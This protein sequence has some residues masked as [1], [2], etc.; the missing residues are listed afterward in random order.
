MDPYR[1]DR[2]W[3]R[4]D[5]TAQRELFRSLR[6]RFLLRH[7]APSGRTL[8]LGS[9]PGRFTPW[10]GGPATARVA[11]DLSNVALGQL[12]AHWPEGEPHPDRVQ[13]DGLRLPFRNGTFA[14]VALLGNTLGFAGDGAPQLLAA[15]A[16]ALTRDGTLILESAPSAPTGSRYLRRLPR[17]ALVRLLRAPIA[18]VRPRVEREPFVT[19]PAPDRTRHGFRPLAESELTD[20]LERVHLTVVEATAVAPALG[21]DPDRLTAIHADPRAWDHLL[22]LEEGLGGTE[23][24]RGAAAALLVAARRLGAPE[25]GIK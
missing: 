17:S 1:V 13:G 18:A 12:L 21:N 2:E 10:V 23:E 19:D 4:Y 11:F 7:A 20:L 15:A 3:K 14:E 16:E 8:D 9:G 22:D 6:E 25:R 5:G 24:R